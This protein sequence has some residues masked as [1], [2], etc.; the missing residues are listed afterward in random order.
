MKKILFLTSLLFISGLT[1]AQFEQKISVNISGGL[2]KT[3]GEKVSEYDPFQMP[4]YGMGLSAAGGLQFRISERFY[5]SGEFGF[6]ASNK[7]DYREGEGNNYLHWSINDTLTGE[8]LEEGD[9]Y[10]DIRNYSF[11]IKPKYYLFHNRKLNPY[12]FAG[13]SL[14]RTSAWLENNWWPAANRLNMLPPDDTGPY[15]WILQE[16]FGMG[17]NPGIGLEYKPDYKMHYF[18]ET[19]IYSILLDKKNFKSPSRE[20]NFNAFVLQAGLRFNFLK[21]KDL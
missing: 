11:G 18:L 10:L 7:W 3:F 13:I 8:L 19:G 20:E 17:F 4:N 15:S 2:F 9:D 1:S 12:V 14:N 16:N 21:S 5:L 6:L